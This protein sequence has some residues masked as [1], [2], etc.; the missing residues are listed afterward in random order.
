MKPMPSREELAALFDYDP[1]T[2]ALTYKDGTPALTRLHGKGYLCGQVNGVTF[3]AHRIIWKL[4][5]DEEPPQVDHR[6]GNRADNRKRNL[7]AA[8]FAINAKNAAK[9]RDNTSGHCG[10]SWNKR[11]GK[12]V[13]YIRGDGQRI[14]LG[15]FTNKR[16]AAKVR[17]IKAREHGFSRRHGTE[18]RA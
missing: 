15:Y 18:L 8:S 9:R 4:L 6:N 17:R 5:H 14:H 13:A 10:V 16:T 11:L 2:G 7:K 1:A 12:W 3:Y